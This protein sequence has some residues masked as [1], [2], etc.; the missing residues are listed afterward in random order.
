MKWFFILLLLLNVVYFGWELDRETAIAISKNR[1]VPA[2]P[3][4][5][6]Q[7]QLL[8]EIQ[9]LPG[10][11]NNDSGMETMA[12]DGMV[13]E[14]ITIDDLVSELPE[15][16]LVDTGDMVPAKSCLRFGPVPK[17]EML[18]EL[19]QWFLSRNVSPQVQYTE[20]E[21]ARLFWIYLD[22]QD[23]RENALAVLDQMQSRGID[24]Y[25]LINRGDLENAI[26][27]GL[28]S[29]RQAVDTRLQELEEKGFVP[30]VVPYTDV[31]RMYWLNVEV[32]NDSMVTGEMQDG[33]PAKYASVLVNCEDMSSPG[34]SP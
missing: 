13:P 33:L 6:Q 32:V 30:V 25:R 27:L 23:S 12:A 31:E 1:S 28:Y 5:G 24:D 21:G 19:Y 20:E 16:M 17:E 7:L 4:S 15:I 29:S 9:T 18:R 8:S 34:F 10:L 3:V 14:L 26:S 2:V 22:P 11:R